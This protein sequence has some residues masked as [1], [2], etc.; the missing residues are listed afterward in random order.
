[1]NGECN[2]NCQFQQHIFCRGDIS[3]DGRRIVTRVAAL[4]TLSGS[5]WPSMRGDPLFPEEEAAKDKLP[6]TAPTSLLFATTG[7]AVLGAKHG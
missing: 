5:G 3:G 1:M 7:S 4:R 6:V 2:D